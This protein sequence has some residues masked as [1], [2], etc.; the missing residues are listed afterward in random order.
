MRTQTRSQ[1]GGRNSAFP[2]PVT[3]ACIPQ[4][5]FF[6]FHILQAN[7]NSSEERYYVRQRNA[8]DEAFRWLHQQLH[9]ECEVV[10]L[11]QTLL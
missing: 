6:V 2:I 9:M 11:R 4:V 7:M 1:G 5:C 3:I 10:A 8:S